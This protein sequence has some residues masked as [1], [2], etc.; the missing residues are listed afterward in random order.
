M[1]KKIKWSPL[2]IRKFDEILEYWTN[3]NKSESFSENEDL[4]AEEDEW[5]KD[6]YEIEDR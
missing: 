1:A 2:A 3:R 6:N 4:Y 5:L